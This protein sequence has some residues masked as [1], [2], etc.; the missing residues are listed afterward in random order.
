[1]TETLFPWNGLARNKPC[2]AA[3]GLFDGLHLGHQEILRRARLAADRMGVESVVFTFRNHPQTV[4]RRDGNPAPR[5]LV[6]PARRVELMKRAG[7]DSIVSPEFTLG[8]AQTPAAVFAREFLARSLQTRHVVVGFNYCFGRG[9]EGRSAD[10]ESFGKVYG[11]EVEVVPAFRVDGQEISSTRIRN[12]IRGGRI[13][14]ARRLLGR[15]HEL[16]GRVI[17]GDGRGESLGF[18]TANLEPDLTPLVPR[19]VY[20]VLVFRNDAREEECLGFGMF[21]LGPRKTFGESEEATSAEVHLLDFNGDLYGA[22]LRLEFLAWIREAMTFPDPEA[23]VRQL[24]RDRT[25]CEAV[26]KENAAVDRRAVE[27]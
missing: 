12:A 14:E 4:L 5:F 27:S 26:F 9:A 15:P 13:D 19:G 17:H 11:F 22:H 18:P 25:A 8:W 3:L 20:A 21:F 16:S 7:V 1:M 6:T 23:L 2:V 24:E 10:L